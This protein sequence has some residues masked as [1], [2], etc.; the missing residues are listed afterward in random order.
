MARIGAFIKGHMQRM[1]LHDEIEATYYLH[2]IDGRKLFQLN[3]AGRKTRE[4]PGKT[5]Q[6]IQLDEQGAKELVAILRRH[7]DI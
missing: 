3:S 4:L 1:T 6:S 5:S 2:D 7:F